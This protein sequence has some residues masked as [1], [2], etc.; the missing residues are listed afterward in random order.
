MEWKD[1][2]GNI[3]KVEEMDT[4]HIINAMKFA[5]KHLD[6]IE[7]LDSKLRKNL[8]VYGDGPHKMKIKYLS[9]SIEGFKIELRERRLNQLLNKKDID[10]LDNVGL[11]I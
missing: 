9:E 5:K 8:G 11:D 1:A 2:N 3:H 6:N 4:S 7:S 10:D